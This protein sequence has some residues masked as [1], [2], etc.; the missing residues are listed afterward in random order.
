M[1]T[2]KTDPRTLTQTTLLETARPYSGKGW[3]LLGY[4]IINYV[5]FL[6]TF[7]TLIA[8][9]GDLGGIRTADRA[10]LD[11]ESTFA[12]LALN[13][14]FLL[15]FVVQHTVMARKKFKDWITQYIS[16]DAERSTYVLA[17]NVV[18]IATM[19]FWQPLPGTF[20]AFEG[21]ARMVM[22]GLLGLGFVV[23]LISTFLI[24]HFHL[25][26][27]KQGY[28]ALKDGTSQPAKFVTPLFYRWV[29]HPLMTGILMVVWSMADITVD[30]L[31]LNVAMTGYIA[32]GVFFEERSLTR[33]LGETYVEY[34]RH[35]PAV[36]PG[37]RP[38]WPP[39]S[40]Q[41]QGPSVA[42]GAA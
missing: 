23:A 40:K 1:S 4:S 16:R 22:H 26:G 21:T 18:F 5:M 36:I 25:F 33:E 38:A 37:L 6:G 31:F 2:S 24:D 12:R 35:V 28:Q 10:W 34:K 3:A 13:V 29:R 19:V 8:F 17:T 39:K 42:P 14:G 20:F 32:I 7:V 27:L 15:L 41:F 9:V 11:L 30:R